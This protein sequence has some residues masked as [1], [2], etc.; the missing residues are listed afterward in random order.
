MDKISQLPADGDD[1]SSLVLRYLDRA[2]TVEE[3]AALRELLLRSPAHR[4]VYVLL[5][6]QRGQLGE[7]MTSEQAL[8]TEVARPRTFRATRRSLARRGTSTWG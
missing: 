1:F 6:R 3:Q 5:A 8:E 4:D 2:V 7:V